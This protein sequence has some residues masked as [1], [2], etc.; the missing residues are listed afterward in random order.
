M[1]S[2]EFNGHEYTLD[3]MVAFFEGFAPEKVVGSQGDSRYCPVAEFLHAKGEPVYQVGWY[4][5]G[6]VTPEEGRYTHADTPKWLTHAL[7]LVDKG[8]EAE[9]FPPVTA[10]RMLEILRG[11]LPDA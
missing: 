5:L 11:E 8:R 9:K 6:W 1:P 10:A 2:F 4:T 7:T 3:D